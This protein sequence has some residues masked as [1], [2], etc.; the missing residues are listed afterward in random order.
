MPAERAAVSVCVPF[1]GSPEEAIDLLETLASLQL[2]EGDELIVADNTPN[3]IL[4][5]RAAGS[6]VRVVAAV[7]RFSSY[8]G[9]NLAAEAAAN[10]W[11]LFVDGDC[12]PRIDLVDR[13]FAPPAGDD[14]GAVAGPVLPL[15][16]GDG[17]IARYA[18]SRSQNKQAPHLRNPFKP[19]GITANL[20]VRRRAWEEVGGFLEVRSGGDADFCWRLQDAGWKIDYREDASLRHFQRERLR[21]YLRVHARNSAA[22]RWLRMRHPGSRM[23]PKPE[24]IPRAIAGTI[25]WP[26]RGQLE[27]GVFK[28]LDGITIA[29]E[30]VG[31]LY[32]N[33]APPADAG[34]RRPARLTVLVD[35]FPVLSQTFVVNEVRAMERLGRRARVVA[36]SRPQRPAIGGSWGIEADWQEDA[37]ILREMLDLGWLVSR[38][39]L[40]CAVDLVARR[41]WRREEAVAPLRVLAPLARSVAEDGVEHLHVHFARRAAL[42][43]LRIKRLLG[44]PY[45]LTAHAWDIFRE[46]CNLAEKVEGAKFTTTGCD[47]NV[48]FLREMV[49]ADAGE[50]IHKIVMG[51][52][53]ERFRRT[54]PYNGDGTVV[55]VGR[56]SE[57]KGFADLIEATALLKG[58]GAE[59]VVI[60][61]DG[62]LRE[63]LADRRRELGVEELVELAGARRPEQVRGLLEEAALLVMPSVVAAD[64]DRD[65]MPVVVKEALA[66]GVPVVATDEVGLPEVVGEGWGRLV[67]PRDP[68]ALAAAIGELMAMSPPE[69]ARMGEAG[70]DFVLGEFG[71]EDQTR[72]LLE[73]IDS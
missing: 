15:L 12:R 14:V 49:G 51:V 36:R 1:L 64:G 44:V 58:G 24:Q 32:G 43:A 73:L 5:S 29:G 62:E 3:G 42:D 46:R 21:P 28:A 38:H 68:S 50:R 19:F 20:L 48:R 39:P 7:E 22:G 63:R 9:R 41:R 35:R 53:P 30:M 27:R 60:V 4:A 47:Y 40:R 25:I 10:D 26:L 72:R 6:G 34:K 37:G 45:S 61:G 57:K 52:D 71:V 16:H 18:A 59:R 69:R 66:M 2:A 33:G 54:K 23:G 11:L 70:R 8:Y 65:S 31:Y 56:L 67:P 17:L 13:Y 55:A